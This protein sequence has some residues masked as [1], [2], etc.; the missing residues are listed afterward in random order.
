MIFE[1]VIA[2]LRKYLEKKAWARYLWTGSSEIKKPK[3][4]S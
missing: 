2:D 1:A 3:K 4:F